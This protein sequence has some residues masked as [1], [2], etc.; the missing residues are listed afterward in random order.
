MCAAA[1]SSSSVVKN[2]RPAAPTRE[3]PS[4]SASS[5]SR[6][7]AAVAREVAGEELAVAVVVGLD[8]HEPA[9][10]ELARDALDH[11]ARERQRARAAERPGGRRLVGARED[12]FGGDVRRDAVAAHVV[13]AAA[14]ARARRQRQAQVR[15]GRRQP[16]LA[17]VERRQPRGALG[18][19]LGVPPPAVGRVVGRRA[20]RSS[21]G[22]GR[23]PR[24]TASPG[25]ARGRPARPRR[26]SA[27][28]R[29]RSARRPCRPRGGRA[30]GPARSVTRRTARAGG[31]SASTCGSSLPAIQMMP[32]PSRTSSRMRASSQAGRQSSVSSG[33]PS[34]RA[35]V[36]R[37]SVS[38]TST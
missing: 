8:A 33:A 9:A 4:T 7:G 25:R 6:D 26:A 20:G 12:L 37:G 29:R 2:G 35:R 17:Q 23:A 5:P 19:L 36:M 14:P 27:R 3:E 32:A 22:R 10:P 16:Q 30:A 13:D 38:S 11:A 1:F 21:G 31:T 15:A 28:R 34:A 18:E 24:P